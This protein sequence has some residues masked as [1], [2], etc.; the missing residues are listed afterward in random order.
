MGNSRYFLLFATLPLVL[1]GCQGTMLTKASKASEVNQLKN[2]YAELVYTVEPQ[3]VLRNGKRAN[4]TCPVSEK[5]TAD[6]RNNFGV[7]ESLFAAAIDLAVNQA[8]TA[9]KDF[10]KNYADELDATRVI[11]GVIKIPKDG[12]STC[13]VIVRGL[14][15]EADANTDVKEKFGKFNKETLKGLGYANYPDFYMEILMSRKG[16][17]VMLEPAYVLYRDTAAKRSGNGVKD[18]TV[19][20][21][22]DEKPITENAGE[23][24]ASAAVPFSFQKSKFGDEISSNLLFANAREYTLKNDK[25]TS[26][27]AAAVINESADPTRAMQFLVDLI[28][29]ENTQS[30][31]DDISKK[32]SDN[33]ESKKKS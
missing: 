10:A 31:L 8:V 5:G 4:Q 17:K 1:A 2:R 14:V 7:V 12:E 25:A 15:G 23:E 19:A 28:G 3:S 24:A 16:K 18:I 21:V 9:V 29:H 22:M 13:I 32:A 6:G 30:L 20:L 26:S 27:N 11:P 33:A